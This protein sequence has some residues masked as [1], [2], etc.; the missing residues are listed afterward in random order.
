VLMRWWRR[1][2][3]CA[4]VAA[5]Q[6]C[7]GQPPSPAHDTMT[8]QMDKAAGVKDRH[9]DFLYSLPAVQGA[10]VGVS[11][12][13]PRRVVIQVFVSRSLTKA[14]RQKFPKVIEGVPLEIVE[15]GEIRT[16]PSGQL[17]PQRF[18]TP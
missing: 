16:L 7:V 13:R 17:Q 12:R 9:M 3:G 2:A 4:V 8:R 1:L 10:G 11:K 15:T 5:L 14:E 18:R 6:V